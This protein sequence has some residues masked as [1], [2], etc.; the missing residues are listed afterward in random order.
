MNP[1]PY[2]WLILGVLVAGVCLSLMYAVEAG[3]LPP[4]NGE[5]ALDMTINVSGEV[6]G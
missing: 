6:V 2:R 5:T 3:V 4:N 1:P